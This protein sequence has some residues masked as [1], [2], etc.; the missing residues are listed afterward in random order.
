MNFG[1]AA[2]KIDPPYCPLEKLAVPGR[3]EPPVTVI[4]L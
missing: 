1:L 2:N 3:F 4:M